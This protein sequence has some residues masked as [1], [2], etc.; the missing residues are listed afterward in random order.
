LTPDTIRR[1][2]QT[3]SSA[4]EG[5]TDTTQHSLLLVASSDFDNEIAKLDLDLDAHARHLL[6][7]IIRHRNSHDRTSTLDLLFVS[8]LDSALFGQVDSLVEHHGDNCADQHDEDHE[9]PPILPG[10]LW[11]HGERR[12]I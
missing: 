6:W 10:I 3:Y 5:P 12:A 8:K 9:D 2:V 1:D 4:L 11:T 7:A